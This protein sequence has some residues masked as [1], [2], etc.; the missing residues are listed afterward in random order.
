[1]AKLDG[2]SQN[3][4]VQSIITLAI[5]RV[6]LKHSGIVSV[7]MSLTGHMGTEPNLK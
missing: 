7:T 4:F 3:D 5:G 1:M 2:F 6:A